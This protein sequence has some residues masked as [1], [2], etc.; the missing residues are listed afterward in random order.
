MFPRTKTFYKNKREYEYLVISESV[1]KQGKGSTTK[2]IVNLGNVNNFKKED[3]ENII[4]GLIKIFQLE[5][6]SVSKDAEIVESLELGSIIFWQKLWKKMSLDKIIETQVKKR[7]KRITLKVAKY[8]Q[9]MAINRCITPLSKL[10]VTRWYNTTCYKEMKGFSDL[11]L[12]V[13]YFYRSM[14]QLL[15]VKDEIELEIYKKLRNLFSVNVKLTFYDITSTFFYSESCPISNDGYSRDKRPDKEQIVI[16]VVTS[17]E[18]Y[19]L[20]HYV[21]TGNTKDEKTVEEVVRSL[22]D[23]YNIEET[24]F[25]G[26]RGMITK[27]NLGKIEKNGFSYIMGV[28]SNQDEICQMIFSESEI[29]N[30]EYELYNN[31]NN[32]NN[33]NNL[34]IREKKI[35][36]KNF[37]LWKTK[38]FLNDN[39]IKIIEKEFNLFEIELQKLTNTDKPDYKKVFKD[40]IKRIAKEIDNKICYKIF[41]LIKKYLGKYENELRFVVCLNEEIKEIVKK[42]REVYIAKLSEELDKVFSS[43]KKDKKDFDIEKLINKVFEG[44]LSKYRKFFKI[45]REESSNKA[46]GYKKD[47]KVID[48]EEIKDGIFILISDRNDLPISKIVESYKNLKEVEQLFDDLKNF[49]DIRPVRHWLEIRVRAHVFICIIGLL[50][51]RIFEINYLNSKFVTE[52]LEEISKVKLV[53]YKVK[54]SKKE[55]RNKI[56]PKVTNVTQTQKKYFDLIGVKNPMSLEKFLWC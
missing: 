44:Y 43:D 16:G 36:I 11:S 31:N 8:V 38:F 17:Y 56:L 21:F 10:A 40:I 47:Q 42:R 53:K 51:K 24:T 35:K 3:I 55:N 13:E 12:N 39:N 48:S 37:L 15:K 22:K 32:N 7:D 14:D 46:V 5:T 33:S 26:D 52:P 18:G 30:E 9:M 45:S 2:D 41:T 6:Y 27:L 49:V 25:V 4:D 29:D 20:K 19:P 54:F 28:K 1:Y 50:L 34:K 23:E